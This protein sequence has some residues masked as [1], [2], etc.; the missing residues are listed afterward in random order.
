[1]S[2]SQR[3][4]PPLAENWRLWTV[5]EVAERL[6]MSRTWVYEKA[7][8]GELPCLHLG[9]ALRFDPEAVRTYAFGQR[10]PTPIIPFPKREE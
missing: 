5:K 3:T 4:S 10:A 8:S 6:G 9:G 1:M 7:A 2:T